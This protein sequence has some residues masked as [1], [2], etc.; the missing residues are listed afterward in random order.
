M[1]SGQGPLFV[2]V[3]EPA[4]GAS[5]H[6]DPGPIAAA[7]NF[8]TFHFDCGIV[9]GE[10]PRPMV[11]FPDHLQ[12]IDPFPCA[13]R[14]YACACKHLAAKTVAAFGHMADCVRPKC[15]SV[16]PILEKGW[17]REGER[18]FRSVT[19]GREQKNSSGD[20]DE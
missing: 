1:T 7:A 12:G 4:P 17:R 14:L 11:S 6:S 15:H 5:T 13:F 8:I 10:R 19:V 9:G 20:G 16:G 3:S 18:I 2:F